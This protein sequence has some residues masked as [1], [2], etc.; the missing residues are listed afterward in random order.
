VCSPD[1]AQ[2]AAPVDIEQI[3]SHNVLV[4]RKPS[5]LLPLEIAILD[6]GLELQGPG[7]GR[8]HGFQLAKAMQEREGARRL[9][10]HGTLYKALGRLQRAGLLE[11]AWE[12]PLI[13]AEQ[14][15]PRRRLYRVTA[16]GARALLEADRQPVKAPRTTQEAAS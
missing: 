5:V 16:V 9:T 6:A 1:A 4:R 10:A 14:G 12:D 2:G 8:F 15:R 3:S 11:S 7:A 13:A